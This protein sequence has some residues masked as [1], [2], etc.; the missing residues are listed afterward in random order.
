MAESIPEKDQFLIAYPNYVLRETV[1]YPNGGVS[2]FY[3]DGVDMVIIDD[4]ICSCRDGE[5]IFP[6]T[7]ITDKQNHY[8]KIYRR[9]FRFL[10]FDPET[11]EKCLQK[12]RQEVLYSTKKISERGEHADS[13]PLELLF[14]QNFTDV[15]GM[16]ALKYLQKE[17][18]ISDEDGNNYF[19]D[20]LVDT[21]DSRVAIEENGIHYHHPQL[22]G[23]EG[24]RKQ[25]RKQNTCALWGLKLYRFSTEDCRFKDRIEDDIRSYL[26]KDTSGFRETGLLLERKTE[27]YEHQEISLAQIEERREKGIRAFLIVLPTAAGKSRIVEEDI[28]KFAAGKEQFRALILSPNTNIIADWKE[29]IE[30][31]LQPLQDRIDIKTYSYAVRHYHEKTRDYYSYIVVDEINRGNA[32]AIFGEIFQLLDRKEADNYPED[33]VG[34]SEYGISNYEVAE[35][36]YEN[37]DHEVK[38]P[39]NLFI[40]AT[41]NTADQNVF[42][43]DTAFQRRWQMEHI[44]NKF[45]FEEGSHALDPIQGTKVNW[46]TFAMVINDQ[47]IENNR[48][49]SS[50]EDKRLG[51]FF[52]KKNELNAEIFPEKVLKYL[53]DDAFKMEREL[54]FDSGFGSLEQVIE[55]YEDSKGDKLQAVLR[56]ELYQ[57]MIKEMDDR[58]DMPMKN[59][60]D[61]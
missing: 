37:S 26:G 9:V 56:A 6:Y 7:L 17:F 12:N 48:D 32:P 28:Q 31:D 51:T 46:G 33:V 19:L 5:Q 44:P 52:V 54:V 27:L 25:L 8:M 50:S 40:L 34:E 4:E 60:G 15:Y 30:N 11:I 2:R 14:E 42:T 10:G 39:S 55:V 20:Y 41:M 13:S 57:K 45:V 61:Q 35:I 59:D 21:A 22:I 58:A 3:D 49:I 47:I 23:I 38:I 36:V 43:L 24:Y 1:T 29:R 53:W 18:R 16:R